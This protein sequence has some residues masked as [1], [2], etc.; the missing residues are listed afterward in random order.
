MLDLSS[1][2]NPLPLYFYWLGKN[3]TQFMDF[4]NPY[5]ILYIYIYVYMYALYYTLYNYIQGR[6]TV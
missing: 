5:I 1:V 3:D 2:R 6:I 4:G